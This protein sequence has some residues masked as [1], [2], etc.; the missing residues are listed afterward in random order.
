MNKK[1][2]SYI[3]LILFL[4]VLDILDLAV[5]NTCLSEPAEPQAVV[6]QEDP[7]LAAYR[8]HAAHS[9]DILTRSGC[10]RSSYVNE[11]TTYTRPNLTVEKYHQYLVNGISKLWEKRCVRHVGTCK[12]DAF[13]ILPGPNEEAR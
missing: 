9:L 4:L 6:I 13:S 11:M 2:A 3:R 7:A 1:R 8:H 10:F 12:Y 5:I